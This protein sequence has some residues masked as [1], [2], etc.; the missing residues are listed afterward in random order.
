MN[1]NCSVIDDEPAGITMVEDVIEQTFG[2]RLCKS[3]D[4][5]FDALIFFQTHGPV[6]IIFLDI[7]MPFIN[8]IE[9]ATLLHPYCTFL[10]FITAHREYGPEAF[11]V[12]A[13]GYLLKPLMKSRFLELMDKLRKEKI[14]KASIQKDNRYLLVKGS[15][16]NTYTNI[17]AEGILYIKA[18]ANYIQIF[19]S[20]GIKTTQ[21][22]LGA[23]EKVLEGNPSFLKINRSTIIA[24]D[25]IATID[26]YKV[27]MNDQMDFT[28][29]RQYK[30]A[31]ND[32][33]I[34][35]ALNP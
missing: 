22:G 25:K 10:I 27:V 20:E 11:E 15:L 24:V 5:A 23:I 18:M 17:W 19:Q 2:I 34:K 7:D 31:F 1:L 6:D 8:G 21:M 14:Q 33:V 28:V 16:K 4:N 9:A 12:N 13:D 30:K 3:F 35:K 26:G 32:F 29:G